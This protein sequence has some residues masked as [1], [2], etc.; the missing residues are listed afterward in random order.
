MTTLFQPPAAAAAIPSYL[1]LRRVTFLSNVET[2]DGERRAHTV[3]RKG[4]CAV[5]ATQ[6]FLKRHLGDRGFALVRLMHQ[7]STR[8]GVYCYFSGDE[9]VMATIRMDRGAHAGV[10]CD[11]TK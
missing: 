1:A 11:R 6:D 5:E 9:D 4:R 10:E 8:R 2:V 3:D 7:A